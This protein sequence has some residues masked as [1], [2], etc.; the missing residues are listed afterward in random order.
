MLFDGMSAMYS[1]EFTKFIKHIVASL[2]EKGYDPYKQLL[3]R[4]EVADLR[5]PRGED[6]GLIC[7]CFEYT[8]QELENH[9]KNL[10]EYVKQQFENEFR[11]FRVMIGNVNKEISEFNTRLPDLARCGLEGRKKKADDFA[12]ISEALEIPLKKSVS[13]PNVTPIPL[14]RIVRKPKQ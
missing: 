14:K 7:L 2:A 1:V 5:A 11:S 10:L 6:C 3:T 8:N 4:F 13:A 12:A 9:S